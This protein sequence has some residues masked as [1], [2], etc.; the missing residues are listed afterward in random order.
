MLSKE[1]YTSYKNGDPDN[2]NIFSQCNKIKFE[3]YEDIDGLD[4]RY[5]W[6][7]NSPEIKKRLEER[8]DEL[9]KKENMTEEEQDKLDRLQA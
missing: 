7:H 8:L 3:G 6:S 4:T 5:F 1:K 2:N 9:D